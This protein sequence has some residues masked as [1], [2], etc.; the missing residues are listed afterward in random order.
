MVTTEAFKDVMAT[1]CAPVTVMTTTWN[2]RPFGTTVSAFW[3]VSLR[4]PM[5]GLALAHDSELLR[6]LRVTR[7]LGVNLLGDGQE[8]LAINFARKADSKFDG[9]QWSQDDGLPRLTAAPG[10]LVCDVE[11]FVGA[12]DH[13]L[14]VA[15]VRC[16]AL[17]PALPLVYAQRSFGTHSRLQAMRA[18]QVGAGADGGHA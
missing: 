7:C 5:V 10:W 8:D 1:V 6:R 18:E 2:A 12:G 16:V 4:P 15:S 11:Q 9:V 3:S 13:V 14:T 17:Q